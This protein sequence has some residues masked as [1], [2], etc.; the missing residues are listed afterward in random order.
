M[1]T[2]LAL[3]VSALLLLPFAGLLLSGGQWDELAVSGTA[4]A[5]LTPT[6]L[7][8]LAVL[9]LA[10]LTNFWVTSRSGNNPFKLQRD[11]FI[12]ISAASAGLGWLLAY[13]NYY[14]MSWLAEGALDASGV[15]MQSLL[16]ALLAPAVLSTRA[17]LGSFGG[18]L[19]RLSYTLSLPAPAND[20]TAFILAPLALLGLIGGAA[21]PAQL[22]WLL[23]TAPLLLLIALQLLWHESSIFSGVARGDW[24]RIV[25]AAL[26]GLVVGNLAVTVFQIAGGTLIMQLPN[27]AFTQLG[28]VLFGLLCLQL[29]DVIAE[30][31]RG[32]T[33]AQVF[34]KKPFPIPVVVKK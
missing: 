30:L 3:F 9:C 26:S 17:L 10:L 22:F 20:T 29:G 5:S 6:V 1:K 7:T 8:L 27:A 21:W 13:L 18:L 14:S 11:Y 19:K 25:C 15:V 31:W 33:R 4:S 32:K 16:F 34:K 12:A 28:Y 24:G 2:R 23:W